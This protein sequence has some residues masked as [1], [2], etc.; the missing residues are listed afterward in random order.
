MS[1]FWRWT[2]GIVV[3]LVLVGIGTFYLRE[4]R[5]PTN[6]TATSAEQTITLKM[7]IF[8]AFT[9]VHS[10]ARKDVQIAYL[11]AVSSGSCA[12]SKPRVTLR[13]VKGTITAPSPAPANKS[14]DLDGAVVTFALGLPGGLTQT[15]PGIVNSHDHPGNPDD[16][17]QWIDMKWIPNVFAQYVGNPIHPNWSTLPVVNGRVVLTGGSLSGHK[18]TDPAATHGM[19][20]F[21]KPQTPSVA[22]SQAMTNAVDYDATLHGSVVV[23]NLTRAGNNVIK[24]DI[25][26]EN[27]EVRLALL[28]EHLD[29]P[30]TIPV[31]TSIHHFCAYY[32]LLTTPP[33]DAEQLLPY[34]A[35]PQSTATAP[36]AVTSSNSPIPGPLC[37]GDYAEA[38]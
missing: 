22:F 32:Q 12:V 28:S 37:P 34:Y 15:G 5:P 19:W 20:E 23:I 2:F 1:T 4:R 25:A 10:N 33:T 9:Y 31:G 18:P 7:R 27:G 6:A 35:G 17:A 16:D 3:L 21:K 11:N 8:G 24:I 14:F 38:P 36:P 29:A 13:V 30:A 26:P